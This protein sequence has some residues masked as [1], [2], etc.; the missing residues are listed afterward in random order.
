MGIR[1]LELSRLEKYAAGL[2]IKVHYRKATRNSPAAEHVVIGTK[3][4]IVLYTYSKISK[5][6]LILNFVHELAHHMSWVYKN[7]KDDPALIEALVEED[8]RGE[9]DPPIEKNKRK[10]IYEMERDDA[11]FRDNV[12]H[13]LD[14]KVSPKKIWIDKEL[15]KWVYKRYYLTGKYPTTKEVK[16]QEK[17]LRRS[18]AG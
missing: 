4:F 12:I 9:D 15:D 16:E 10:L 17:A 2:G 1:D 13:E 5:T 11:D 3:P 18:Y 7:R 6:Q 8:A 14:I